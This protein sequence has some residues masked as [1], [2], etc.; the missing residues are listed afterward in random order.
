MRGDRFYKRGIVMKR[1]LAL[2]MS[3][4]ALFT[5]A[6][7]VTGCDDADY[8]SPQALYEAHAAG[9][10]VVG[11]TVDLYA[12]HDYFMGQ[13]FSGPTPNLGPTMY[14]DATG[15]GVEDIKKS[16]HIRVRITS[17]DSDTRFSFS[18]NSE[19]VD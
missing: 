16:D 15:E 17:I 4:V 19:L 8:S 5:M 10:D 18:L 2:I 13:I 7:A 11:K 14:I 12:S 6:F 3:I 1:L 9:E